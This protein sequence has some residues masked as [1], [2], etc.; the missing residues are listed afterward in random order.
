MLKATCILC[1][2]LVDGD[3][4]SKARVVGLLAKT[5]KFVASPSGII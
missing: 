2:L 3:C 5:T 4:L 1:N